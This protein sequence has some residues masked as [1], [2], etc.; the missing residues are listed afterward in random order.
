VD[1][2][3]KDKLTSRQSW[4]RGVLTEVRDNY[5]NGEKEFRVRYEYDSS[6]PLI[7]QGWQIQPVG[8]RSTY[9]DAIVGLKPGDRVDACDTRNVWIEST[10]LERYEEIAED[11]TMVLYYEIGYRVDCTGWGA[12]YD[13]R[14]LATS[15]RLAL[16][17]K[18]RARAFWK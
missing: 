10:V 18:T 9:F 14:V 2:L 11:S 17:P 6:E 13:E 3:K 8:S 4:S 15:P 7:L 12:N 1:C 16:P 5:N